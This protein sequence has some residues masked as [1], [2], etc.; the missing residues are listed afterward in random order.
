VSAAQSVV[1]TWDLRLTS[2]PKH[3]AKSRRPHCQRFVLDDV[4]TEAGRINVRLAISSA[5]LQTRKKSPI[6]SHFEKKNDPAIAF[7]R[8]S[9][10][11]R[12][13]WFRKVT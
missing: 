10:A 4:P 5:R 13:V 7:Y 11:F 8:V 6:Y 9:F 1:V 12:I 2:Q 3:F